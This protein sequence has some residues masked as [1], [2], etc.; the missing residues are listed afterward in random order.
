[1]CALE[2]IRRELVDMGIQLLSEESSR[3]SLIILE[4]G[5]R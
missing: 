1:M 4:D 3:F 5:E 2:T